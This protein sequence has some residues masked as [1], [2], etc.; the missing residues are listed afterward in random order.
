MTKNITCIIC[1]T[2]CQI[3]VNG[4]GSR[5]DSIENYKCGRG[6]VYAKKEFVDPS[7]ILTSSVAVIDS[8]RCLVPIRSSQPISLDRLFACM[9]EIKKITVS[10]PVKMHQVIISNILDTGVDIIACAPVER[11]DDNVQH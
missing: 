3:T 4:E 1:P 8:D 2:G 7:R 6:K 11:S 10:A 9:E 5:I